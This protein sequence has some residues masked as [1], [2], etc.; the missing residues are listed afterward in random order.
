MRDLYLECNGTTYKRIDK[1]QARKIYNGNT[2]ENC[3]TIICCPCQINPFNKWGAYRHYL[4]TDRYEI[5]FD[6]LVDE[7]AWRT[8]DDYNGRYLSYYVESDRYSSLKR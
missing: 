3:T 7:I 8:C 5:S 1:R 6:A 4:T 2:P